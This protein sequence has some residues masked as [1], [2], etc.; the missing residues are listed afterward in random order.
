MAVKHKFF[1][2]AS[3]TGY[4][5]AM[6]D[7]HTFEWRLIF[8]KPDTDD[9]RGFWVLKRKVWIPYGMKFVWMTV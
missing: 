1:D 8:T 2:L 4:I 6:D 5:D 7:P 9:S 3:A